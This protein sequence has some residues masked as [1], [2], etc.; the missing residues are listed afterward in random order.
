MA[1]V[2]SNLVLGRAQMAYYNG[3]R[4]LHFRDRRSQ[5]VPIQVRPP[6]QLIT[7]A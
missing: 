4:R 7:R 5:T 6:I 3:L 2:G 1:E